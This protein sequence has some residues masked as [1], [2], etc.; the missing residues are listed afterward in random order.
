M[1]TVPP[2]LL[3]LSPRLHL[4]S[5]RLPGRAGRVFFCGEKQGENH[6]HYIIKKLFAKQGYFR[7]TNLHIKSLE[8]QIDLLTKKVCNFMQLAP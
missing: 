7:M 3:T 4:L 1:P 8:A 2:R 5:P 6:F